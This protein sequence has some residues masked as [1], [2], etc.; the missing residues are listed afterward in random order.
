MGLSVV[1]A[2]FTLL[3]LGP[4]PTHL[5][6]KFDSL[7]PQEVRR[8]KLFIIK[9]SRGWKNNFFIHFHVL[10]LMKHMFFMQSDLSAHALCACIIL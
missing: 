2:P 10:L 8:V 3:V 6:C 1:E 9:K 7:E 4:H 5:V